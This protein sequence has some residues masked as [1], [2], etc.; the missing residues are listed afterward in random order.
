M[1]NLHK[2]DIIFESS[3]VEMREL[4]RFPHNINQLSHLVSAI[5]V[6]LQTIQGW[7]LWHTAMEHNSAVAAIATSVTTGLRYQSYVASKGP[8][9]LHC[10][11]SAE[12]NS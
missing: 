2:H 10:L 1:S 12:A 11:L 7:S 4:M 5:N 6:I 3:S 8:A 9:W